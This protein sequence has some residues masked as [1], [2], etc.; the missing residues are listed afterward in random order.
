VVSGKTQI[1]LK[2]EPEMG[3]GIQLV[4]GDRKTAWHLTDYLRD[5]EKE[6]MENLFKDARV[7]S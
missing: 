5:L 7:K 6:I 2:P 4:A 3:L 1:Q